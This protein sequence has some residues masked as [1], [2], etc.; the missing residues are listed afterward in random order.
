MPNILH[1]D[2]DPSL[3]RGLARMLTS[4]VGAFV[5][6]SANVTDAMFW[7]NDS[8]FVR[9]R[10]IDLIVLDGDLGGGTNGR[11]LFD[12]LPPDLQARCIFFAGSPELFAGLPNPLIEKPDT[13]ALIA[14]IKQLIASASDG[15]GREGRDAA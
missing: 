13:V 14:A 9:G 7:V 15:S 6:S 1:V 4:N 3:R 8:R 12:A 5:I 10:R 2:D 11:Q